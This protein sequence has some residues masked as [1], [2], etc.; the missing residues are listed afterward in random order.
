MRMKSLNKNLMEPEVGQ[1]FHCAGKTITGLR[2]MRKLSVHD[3]A[4]VIGMDFRLLIAA[5]EGLQWMEPEFYEIVARHCQVTARI[6]LQCLPAHCPTILSAHKD[7][8]TKYLTDKERI[9]IGHNASILLMHG[10]VLHLND[11]RNSQVHQ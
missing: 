2:T 10:S 5:E 9:R 1:F 11:N 6:F 8:V 7:M 4:D 3:L